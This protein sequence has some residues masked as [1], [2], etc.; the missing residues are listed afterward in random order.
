V[1]EWV[2]LDMV[3]YISLLLFI[4][5]SCAKS[6]QENASEIDAIKQV[7]TTQQ[8]CWNNGDI[9][10]FML[11]Y[12]NSEKFKFSWVNGTEYGWENAL[13]KYKISYPTKESMG[14]FRFELLDVILTSD[15]TAT[16]NGKWELIRINDNPKGSFT[17]IFKKIENNWL[18]ISDYTTD[19]YYP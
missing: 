3:R 9:E 14:E 4:F 18:I 11:G 13:E 16:L 1:G 8:I 10:G 2:D 15:T 19:E 5:N 12:W 6:P 7:L 17:Y